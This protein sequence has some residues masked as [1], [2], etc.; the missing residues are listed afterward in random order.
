MKPFPCRH[1]GATLFH[2]RQNT[3]VV[4]IFEVE[5][6]KSRNILC[7]RCGRFTNFCV[8]KEKVEVEMKI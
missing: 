1:C 2:R 5:L 8:G 7:K 3:M 6:K 4:S